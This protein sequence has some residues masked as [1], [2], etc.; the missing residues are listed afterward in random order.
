M[1]GQWSLKIRQL[2][3]EIICQWWSMGGRLDT[4]VVMNSCGGWTVSACDRVL[5][6]AV[7]Q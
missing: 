3:D 1:N 7:I 5:L 2:E 4:D 6:S